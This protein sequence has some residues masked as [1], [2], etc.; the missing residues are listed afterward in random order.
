MALSDTRLKRILVRVETAMQAVQFVAFPSMVPDD[1][2][3]LS[4]EERQG[5]RERLITAKAALQDALTG[6]EGVPSVA[7]MT[8][9]DVQQA[10]VKGTQAAVD[11]Q[12]MRRLILYLL[13]PEIPVTAAQRNTAEQ[14]LLALRDSALAAT[15]Q[16]TS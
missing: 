5:L 2:N 9:A 4:A 15:G 11:I 10:L 7:D 6:A 3:A 12:A 14:R 1:I 8:V 13:N 16:I